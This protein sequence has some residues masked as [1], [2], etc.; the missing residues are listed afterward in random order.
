LERLT[1]VYDVT[2][3]YYNPNIFPKEEYLRRLSEQRRFLSDAY[4]GEVGLI[5]GEY[6]PERF[7]T[8]ISGFEGFPEGSERCVKCYGLRLG[9]TAKTARSRG[10]EY[11]VTTLSVSPRKN[12]A[13]INEISAALSKEHG[14]KTFYADFKKKDGYKRSSELSKKYGL[15]RQ[16]YCGCAPK[17][18]DYP[19]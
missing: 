1:A 13:E 11:F 15:Y 18:R 2:L 3:F 19:R 10:Y 8:A 6:E 9:E 12:A 17:A 14:I 16:D 7:K 5:E 4:R